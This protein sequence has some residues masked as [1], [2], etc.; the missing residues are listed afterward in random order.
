MIVLFIKIAVIVLSLSPSSTV[1][2]KIDS[3]LKT[4]Y[5]V[6][7]VSLSQLQQNLVQHID[8]Q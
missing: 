1:D 7:L 6:I 5:N 2:T 4:F 3:Y 8:W